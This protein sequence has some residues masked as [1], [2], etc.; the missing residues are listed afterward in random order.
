MLLGAKRFAHK[1]H[2][3][4][5]TVLSV[6]A[7]YE[8]CIPKASIEPKAL[9]LVGRLPLD[10]ALPL[11]LPNRTA[12]VSRSGSSLEEKLLMP[13]RIIS[14]SLSRSRRLLCVAPFLLSILASAKERHFLYVAVPGVQN[15]YPDN[16]YNL[17]YGGIGILVFDMDHERKA[18]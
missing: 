10:R 2:Y 15:H 5:N 12:V 8:S 7:V 9:M 14:N 13:M 3:A 6:F 1:I 17:R 4:N 16:N 11:Y 18:C